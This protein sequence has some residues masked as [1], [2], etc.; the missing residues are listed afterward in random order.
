MKKAL[1][2]A[3]IIFVAFYLFTQPGSSDHLIG[4]GFHS[5]HDAGVSLAH[6]ARGLRW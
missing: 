5:L 2:W 1:A 3:A 6:F 4:N